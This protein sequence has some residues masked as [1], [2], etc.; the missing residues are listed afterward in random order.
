MLVANDLSIR[1]ARHRDDFFE[2]NRF[3]RNR[4]VENAICGVWGGYSFGTVIAENEFTGNGGWLTGLSAAASTWNT[5]PTII[6]KNRFLNNK[7]A[8][9]LWWNDGGALSEVSRRRRRGKGVVGNVIAGNRFEINRDAPFKNLRAD[10]KLI[11]LQLRDQGRAGSRAITFSTTRSVSTIRGVEFAVKPGCEP[12]SAGQA[13]RVQIP[14]YRATGR[15]HPVGARN[16]LRGRDQIIM[17][18]WGPWDHES[19]LVRPVKSGAGEHVFDVFG[20]RKINEVKVLQGD[21]VAQIVT[22]NTG[23]PARDA[24]KS[25]SRARSGIVTASAPSRGWV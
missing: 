12:L 20:L 21:V 16:H 13:P 7:C 17:D 15:T 10:A 14:K 18:E 3:I 9:H 11:L 8:I 1:R 19:P 2:G 4:L 25:T 5:P 23:S 6:L 24:M 22:T